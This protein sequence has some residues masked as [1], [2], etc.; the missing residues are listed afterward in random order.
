MAV[1]RDIF[2]IAGPTY[3]KPV[4]WYVVLARVIVSTLLG[5]CVLHFRFFKYLGF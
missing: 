1:E 2:G 3:L 4:N 5:V